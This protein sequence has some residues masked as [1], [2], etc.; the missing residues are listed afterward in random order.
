MNLYKNKNGEFINLDFFVK[1]YVIKDVEGDYCIEGM[2][3]HQETWTIDYFDTEHK[4]EVALHD[5]YH[6]YS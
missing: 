1:I 2:D 5:I 4:A 6:K 3:T